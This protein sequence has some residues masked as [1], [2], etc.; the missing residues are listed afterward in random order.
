MDNN[1]DGIVTVSLVICLLENLVL[2]KFF[3]SL[4]FTESEIHFYWMKNITN[5]R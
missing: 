2:E 4:Y 5:R 3:Y 1:L